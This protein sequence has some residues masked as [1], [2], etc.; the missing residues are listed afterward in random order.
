MKV[1]L[2]TTFPDFFSSPLASS[3]VQRAQA[4][5]VLVV[6]TMQLRDFA[7]DSHKT[8]D[9]RPFG[10]GAGMVMKIEPI[11]AALQSL[12]KK[13]TGVHR[14][15][16]LS[17]RGKRF[18]QDDAQRLAQFQSLTFICGHYGDVDQRVAEHLAD[19]ELS[20][21][22]F[23]LTGGEP[24]ALAMLDAVARLL[25]GV[26]GNEASLEAESHA[27]VGQPSAPQY[28]RPA[29]YRGW[30][31]PDALL[32]GNPTRIAQWK[33]QFQPSAGEQNESKS[34]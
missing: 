31:V 34:E 5:K 23:V 13:I 24:A 10:G 9:D 18:T 16:L 7:T 12:S 27:Q 14:T 32:S 6:E 15:I 25:P 29:E 20:L 3:M 22:D 30:K 28:T 33:A 4:S 1:F 8:T 19:E 26:L 11:D 2:I 21:G 17:A